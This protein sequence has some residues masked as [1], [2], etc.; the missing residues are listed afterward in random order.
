MAYSNDTWMFGDKRTTIIMSIPSRMI[1][2]DRPLSEVGCRKT[3]PEIAWDL[4]R[5]TWK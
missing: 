3:K 4:E 1:T 2:G 5:N